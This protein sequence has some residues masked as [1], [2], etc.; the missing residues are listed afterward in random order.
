MTSQLTLGPLGQIG[1]AVRNLDEMVDFYRDVLGIPF[2]GQ[3]P[4]MAFFDLAGTRLM[5]SNFSE[6]GTELSNST[7]YY[8]VEDIDAGWQALKDRG[9]RL[10]DEP[11]LI[12]KEGERGDL[13]MTFF[14]DPEENLLALMTYR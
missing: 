1:L 3:V 11:H 14:R 6:P 13:W 10:E 2:L 7:L 12:A 5:L 9:V 8:S 4:R